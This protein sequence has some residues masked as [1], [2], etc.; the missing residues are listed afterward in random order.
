LKGLEHR[1]VT[2]FYIGLPRLGLHY[3]STD[4]NSFSKET[5]V[6]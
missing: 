1:E 3:K 5:V 2:F 6:M 4:P